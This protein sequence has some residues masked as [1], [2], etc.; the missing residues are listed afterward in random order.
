VEVLGRG[1]DELEAVMNEA[2][3]YECI[4]A[5]MHQFTEPGR[6]PIRQDLGDELA[7]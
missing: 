7:D 2:A 6:K 3:F 5:D 1:L 4:L